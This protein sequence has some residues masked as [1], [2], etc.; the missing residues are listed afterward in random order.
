MSH[1]TSEVPEKSL[2]LAREAV[3]V[4]IVEPDKASARRL[5]PALPRAEHGVF[6]FEW[7]PSLADALKR[8]A[9]G[10]MDIVLASANLAPDSGSEVFNKFRQVS[11][12]TL[13]LPLG[14]TAAKSAC[15]G[16]HGLDSVAS[17]MDPVWLQSTLEYVARRKATEAEWRLAD[18]ALFEEKERARVTLGSIGDA[19]L[20]TDT[21][22]NVSYLNPVAESLTGW[23][24]SIAYGK[25]L[26][27]VFDITDNATGEQAR[28]PAL[29]AMSENS[30][31]GLAANCVLHRLDGS[32]ARIEDSAAPVHDRNGRVTGA[33]IVFR[34]VNQSRAM[35]R[36]MAWLA[37]HDSLTGVASRVLFEERFRQV[38]SLADRHAAQAAILFVDLDNFKKINDSLGHK[39]GDNLLRTVANHFLSG[40]RDTDTVCRHGGDEFVI[41]LAEVASPAAAKQAATKLLS[42]FSQP[43]QVEGRDVKV[44]MSIGISMYPDDGRDMHSL[45]ARADSAMYQAKAKGEN[46]CEFPSRGGNTMAMDNG[47]LGSP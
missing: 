4:L 7:V 40:V 45:I 19:V 22:G 11:P 39:V 15:G 30:T 6:N 13:A 32:E 8:L 43:I 36:K 33:V 18:E 2:S 3:N 17:G 1:G 16:G 10:D 24:F 47:G 35:T 9:Q 37:R 26:S 44:A 14:V 25:P 12:H 5:E 28:N 29:H 20:V 27:V 41:L 31:V 38:T 42:L 23:S 34:D 46:I 21:E